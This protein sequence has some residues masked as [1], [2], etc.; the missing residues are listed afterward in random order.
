MHRDNR[1]DT[2]KLTVDPGYRL[3][4]E[5]DFDEMIPFVLENIRKRS[6]ISMFYFLSNAFLLGLV[7]LTI[8]KGFAGGG[9]SFSSLL[10]QAGLGILAGSILVIP[11]HE[12][13]HGLAY[14][15]LG[16]RKIR[17]G[18]DLRQFIFYVTAD[19]FPVSGREIYTLAFTPFA[20]INLALVA[21]A[22]AWFPH[23]NLFSLFFLISHNIMCIGDFAIGNFVR[24]HGG[25]RIFSFDEIDRKKSYFYEEI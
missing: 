1:P 5:L 17:F 10:K 20:V 24:F 4:R 13:L 2:E 12:L 16:A 18:A 15:L 3:I 6:F 7:L 23:L 8:I 25:G 9:L 22:L 19:R 21:V 14:R 11:L